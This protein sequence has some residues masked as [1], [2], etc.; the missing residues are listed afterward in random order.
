MGA[1]LALCII[2][3]LPIG[4][5]IKCSRL[6]Q[7][8]KLLQLRLDAQNLELSNIPSKTHNIK[9]ENK[10]HECKDVL[11]SDNIEIFTENK[12]L[13]N[14]IANL[15]ER[16]NGLNRMYEALKEERE[17]EIPNKKINNK[18]TSQLSFNNSDIQSYK[19][20]NIKYSINEIHEHKDD[21]L[22]W[23]I[24]N[25]QHILILKKRLFGN[26]DYEP[27]CSFVNTGWKKPELIQHAASCCTINIG[28]AFIQIQSPIKGIVYY[29]E[30]SILNEGDIILYIESDKE[31]INNFEKTQVKEKLLEKKRKRD[32]EKLALQELINEGEIF[33]DANKRPPI[34][35]EVVDAVWNRDG[36]KCVY[37]GSRDNLHL[38][39]IIPFSKG[40]ATNIE[41]LQL[42][43]QK[44]NLE[45][46]NKI[47]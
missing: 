5:F 46:S 9:S 38:D 6:Y 18:I 12:R 35:K 37:C 7:E 43:C 21:F 45:K 32:L 26:V 11:T 41:N 42:L 23:E 36:G 44:C 39:H 16:Y 1:F 20:A 4:L 15:Q 25:T 10:I 28:D 24:D 8:N 14:D 40:G 13:K 19:Y 17:N 2:I 33:P 29:E 22:A 31:A 47:G 30:K 3:G 34:P 27:H